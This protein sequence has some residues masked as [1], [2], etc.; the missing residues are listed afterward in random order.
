MKPWRETPRRPPRRRP[1]PRGDAAPK[2]N[3]VPDPAD[4]AAVRPVAPT[5]VQTRPGATTRLLTKPGEQPSH[6]Q[7]GLPKIAAT[8]GFVDSTTLLP[9]AR[10]A[11][12][13]DAPGAGCRTSP[14][15]R[16]K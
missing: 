12:R 6:Q 16:A 13:R 9:Q 4:G 14:R 3:V 1:D 10:R 2:S 8:P 15:K 5:V 11:G 7:A